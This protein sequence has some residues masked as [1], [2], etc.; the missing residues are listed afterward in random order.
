MPALEP[1]APKEAGEA[2]APVP[3]DRYEGLAKQIQA[4][5]DLAWKHQQPKLAVNLV[6]LKLFNNQKR[7]P[8]AVGDTTLFT[9]FQ[10]VLASLYID[11][12]MVEFGGK[13]EGDDETADNLNVLAENDYVEMEKDQ[14]DYDW[15]WNTLFFGRGLVALHEYERDP[16]NNVYLPIPEVLDN[17][18]FLRDP[19][20]SSV[21]G[22]RMGRGAA[23]F[24]GR[25]I[26]MTKS[27]VKKHP[28]IFD[29]DFRGIRVGGGT[30]EL[31]QR[32]QEARDTAQGRQIQ[33][34]EGELALGVNAEYDII[35]WHTHYEIKGK[36]EKVKVWLVNERAKVIGLQVLKSE[37]KRVLWPVIDRPLYPTSHDWDGVSIPDLVEDK[38]RAR[39]VAQNLGLSAMKAD[40]YPN[41][42]YDSNKITNR[43]H[44]K[45]GFNKFIPA[46][47]DEGGSIANAILPLLKSRPNMVLLDFIYNSLELS[48]Q[49]AT[50][51]PELKQGMLSEKQRTLGEV[52]I[53]ASESDTRYSLSAKIFGWSEK[54][55]WQQWYRL[56]KDNFEAGIDEKVLRLVGAFGAKWRPLRRSNIILNIDPDVKIESKVL[57]RAKQMEERTSLTQFFALALQEP[58]SNRRWGLKKLAKLNGLEKDEIDRLYPP[59][60]DERI[61]EDENELLNDNKTADVLPD[62]DHNVHLEIHS[63]A[64]D[65][66]AAYAHIE[67]HKQALTMKMTMPELFAP[68]EGVTD[69]QPPGTEPILPVP[70][71][72]TPKPIAPSQ[73]PGQPT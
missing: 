38:Q 39:A 40:L 68:D 24:F 6:R 10:T 33:K 3:T 21:N 44:L 71:Q 19:R 13:E 62:D 7:D 55:F 9:I 43:K 73:A 52:N 30:R 32:A 61:A 11:R 47:P 58:T 54:R 60:I 4:E 51:T 25:P 5:Y 64:G 20:A 14:I 57:S 18:S 2:K 36:V 42:I 69:F 49:K 46:E 17:L 63:K 45:P 66:K 53:V 35:E 70:E 29:S 16:E 8:K 65:T 34:K 26:K 15:D 72:G 22:N 56:Y 12:L 67:T 28:H 31:L 27:D 1:T 23:R 50:A 37:T 59:T 41:Y 48:A